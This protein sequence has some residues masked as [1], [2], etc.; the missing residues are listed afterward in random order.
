MSDM[1]NTSMQKAES[2]VQKDRKGQRTAFCVRSTAHSS[3]GFTLIE[4][5]VAITILVTAIAGPLT[6]ASKGLQSALL[7]RDQ[8]IASFLAQEGVEIVREHRDNNAL[9]S[10]RPADWLEG[11]SACTSPSTCTIDA[12]TDTISACTGTCNALRL[13][14]ASGFYSYALSDSVTPFTRTVTII[15]DANGHEAKV[16]S[17]VSWRTSI[18][19]RQI[20]LEATLFNWQ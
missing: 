7:A 8:L 14:A 11:L 10:P 16:R 6:L 2:S 12:T 13:N 1:K 5:F 15:P 17:T 18:F 3:R 20:T 4:T 9:A 19:M